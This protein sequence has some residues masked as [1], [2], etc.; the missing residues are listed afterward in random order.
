MRSDL[1]NRIRDLEVRIGAKDAT[2]V[3][4]DGSTRAIRVRDPLAV[5]LAAMTRIHRQSTGQVA[6]ASPFN[7]TI[8][9]MGAAESI[10][11]SDSFLQMVH[12]MAKEAVTKEKSQ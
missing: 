12:S 5:L 11:T 3:F 1:K 6:D 9:L 2:L 10:Q 8:D 4:S 7:P